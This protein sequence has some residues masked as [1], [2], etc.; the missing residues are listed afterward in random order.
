MTSS[1][2]R[3]IAGNTAFLGTLGSILLV[4]VSETSPSEKVP[5]AHLAGP[6]VD[7]CFAL[8]RCHP[9]KFSVDDKRR[10]T[11]VVVQ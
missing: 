9:R 4:M 7:L 11:C 10:S 5:C 8:L 2:G 6:M 3:R 1:S